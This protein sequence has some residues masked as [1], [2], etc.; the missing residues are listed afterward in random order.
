MLIM[1]GLFSQANGST[2]Y[3][4]THVLVE[5]K[6]NIR[7]VMVNNWWSFNGVNCKIRTVYTI[8]VNC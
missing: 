6:V 8:W 5:T 3:T 1:F 2:T 4:Y 7:H